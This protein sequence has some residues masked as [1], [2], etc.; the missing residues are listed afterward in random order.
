MSTDY[1]PLSLVF[2]MAVETALLYFTY[3]N[4]IIMRRELN[5]IVLHI[6][7]L[8]RA[9]STVTCI[10]FHIAKKLKLLQYRYTISNTIPSQQVSVK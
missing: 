5:Y 4:V 7:S 10:G 1:T 2:S 6:A 9:S 8:S 3:F